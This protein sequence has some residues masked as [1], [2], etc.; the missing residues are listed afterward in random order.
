MQEQ[1]ITEALEACG[2]RSRGL[3]AESSPSQQL[4]GPKRPVQKEAQRKGQNK[5]EDGKTGEP[6]AS[7]MSSLCDQIGAGKSRHDFS[8]KQG[9]VEPEVCKVPPPVALVERV[10]TV[11][12]GVRS[13]FLVATI[14]L[15]F[16]A[17]I[18][19]FNGRCLARP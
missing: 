12:W 17:A 14:P 15:T 18:R 10:L 5:E 2:F 1:Q 16:P 7:K 3:G 9:G 6:S 11:E 4:V 13:G 8:N 19:W